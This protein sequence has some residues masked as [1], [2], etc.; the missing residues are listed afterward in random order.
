ALAPHLDFPLAQELRSGQGQWLERIELVQ[1]ALFARVVLLAELW[2]SFGVEPAAV[3]G[4]SQGEIAAAV[5]AGALTLEEGA[6]LA[7]IRAQALIALMGKGEMASFVLSAAELEPLLS[8]YGE[9][10]SIAAANGPRST[11]CSGEPEAIAELLAK[12]E[13]DGIR[14][15]LI[16]VG[17]ASHCAQ[18]EAIREQ[19]IEGAADLQPQEARI[20]IYSTVSGALLSGPEL[21]AA[22]WYRN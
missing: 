12:C 22:Y 15:R 21:D 5:V 16:P 7:A 9:R 20:P 3:V 19:L 14:A 2:R 1:P 11:V 18:V 17:Y 10:V 4:H 13:E 6:K 8:P